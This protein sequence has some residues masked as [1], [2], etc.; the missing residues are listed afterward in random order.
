M[1]EEEGR[2][3]HTMSSLRRSARLAKKSAMPVHKASPILPVVV[4]H[5]KAP[6]PFE[7]EIAI[8]REAASKQFETYSTEWYA[9]L[10]KCDAVHKKRQAYWDSLPFSLSGGW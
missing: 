9:E 2:G 6:C 7:A 4:E 10:E 1:G 5:V 8:A 3:T